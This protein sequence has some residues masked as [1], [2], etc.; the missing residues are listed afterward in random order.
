MA[1][2]SVITLKD[3]EKHEC[4]VYYHYLAEGRI[5]KYLESLEELWVEY[6]FDITDVP[7]S[8]LVI[9]FLGNMIALGML[10]NTE[11]RVSSIENDFYNAIPEVV[12][13]YKEMYSG[14]TELNVYVKAERIEKLVIDKK[15]ENSLLFFSGGVDSVYSLIENSRYGRCPDL[16]QIHGA[17]IHQENY[18]AW[19]EAVKVTDIVGKT[20]EVEN[21]LF[22]RSNLH[23][24][25]SQGVLDAYI[26]E[27]YRESFWHGFQHSIGMLTI[28]APLVYSHAY[29]YIYFASTFTAE[30]N[31]TCASSPTIDNKIKIAG[32]A[33]IHSG[34]EA[35]RQAKIKAII[36][37]CNETGVRLPLRVCYLSDSGTNCLKCEKCLRT[38]IGIYAEGHSPSDFSLGYTDEELSVAL[39]TFAFSGKRSMYEKIQKR[40][41]VNRE[42]QSLPSGM[43]PFFLLPFDQWWE[44][45]KCAT[46]LKEQY[47]KLKVWT[48]ELQSGKDWLEMKYHECELIIE[49]KDRRIEELV[50]LLQQQDKAKE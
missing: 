47:E 18:A 3:I 32:C 46:R 19:K 24:Y 16:F 37:Y 39:N 26:Y 35:D 7:D 10:F 5:T 20:V 29:K 30:D 42:E 8:V 23:T 2:D 9:P 25:V 6:D 34:F 12:K 22:A 11:I 21:I 33:V 15:A 45:S 14:C 50:E 28:A 17:D 13:A 48:D 27:N 44:P 36:D 31:Y 4:Y 1:F 38:A 43:R 40:I 49:E 41:K